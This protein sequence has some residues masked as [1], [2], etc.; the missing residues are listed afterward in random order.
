MASVVII[1]IKM[2]KNTKRAAEAKPTGKNLLKW[3]LTS[4]LKGYTRAEILSPKEVLGN[5]LLKDH[6]MMSD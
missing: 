1:S 4:K 6:K 3:Q 2:K 5:N